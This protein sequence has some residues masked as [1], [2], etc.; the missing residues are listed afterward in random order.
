MTFI[1]DNGWNVT[2]FDYK[3][4]KYQIR[5][6]GMKG[7]KV[8][9]FN[10]GLIGDWTN[11]VLYTER[12]SFIK[13]EQLKHIAENV[14]DRIIK[15][16][17]KQNGI[18]KTDVTFY[19]NGNRHFISIVQNLPDIPGMRVGDAVINWT[20]RTKDYSANSLAKYI[21]EK[22]TGYVATSLNHYLRV[23]LIAPKND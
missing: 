14:I 1:I 15:L 2:E 20:A 17:N 3:G 4:F 11:K 23:G 21:R 7:M 18:T 19:V 10:P 5:S 6:K 16:I 13:P 9:I 22:N 8:H 12:Y